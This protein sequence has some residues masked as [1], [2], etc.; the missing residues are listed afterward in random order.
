MQVGL[1]R[2]V[3]FAKQRAR[4]W[5]LGVSFASFPSICSYAVPFDDLLSK[6][7]PMGDRAPLCREFADVVAKALELSITQVAVFRYMMN[8]TEQKL[9]TGHGAA[10]ECDGK[11]RDEKLD[12]IQ[13]Y[14][15]PGVVDSRLVA[16]A[17]K[18]ISVLEKDLDQLVVAKQIEGC[19][20]KSADIVIS[21]HRVT[22]EKDSLA[23]VTIYRKRT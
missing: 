7:Q 8:A 10:V 13:V 19:L 17:S 23:T 14:R 22:C 9:P 12:R 18:G 2:S 15:K 1:E 5:V 20:K 6:L 21:G 4:L 11:D 16:L 3:T